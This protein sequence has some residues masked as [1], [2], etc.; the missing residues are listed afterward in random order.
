MDD[1]AVNKVFHDHECHYYDERFAIVHDARSARRARREVQALLGRSLRDGE[2]VLDVGCGTGWL[3]AGLRRSAPQTHVIGLDLSAGMIE[4]ARA[5]G[6]W[7]LVQGEA[8]GSESA[9]SLPIANSS[10]DL[11]VGRGVLHHLP[12]PVAALAE[13]RRVLKPNGT[14]VLSIEPTPT[15]ERH[16]DVLV[17]G[18]LSV[19]RTPLAP[20][21]EFWELAA[22]AANL[23]V[24]TVEEL[25]AAATAAGFRRVELTTS[26]MAATLVLTA[27]YVMHGRLPAVARRLPWRELE[28]AGRVI[29]AAVLDRIVPS[30][31]RH[32]VIGTLRP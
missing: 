24:F 2:V 12:D 26:A 10:V 25:R 7:P 31:M 5:A 16:G 4:R 18:M 9:A 32:T 28:S 14:V 17:R 15:V 20:E 29:D 11:V 21:D 30:G 22:M 8:G 6:A 13:W 23:H 27:S 3:A 19:M 1:V